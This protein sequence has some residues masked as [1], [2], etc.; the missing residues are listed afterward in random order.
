MSGQ[1]FE[2]GRT[3]YAEARRLGPPERLDTDWRSSMGWVATTLG[4]HRDALEEMEVLAARPETG[5]RDLLGLA[6]DLDEVGRTAEARDRL[7]AL[8]GRK[9]LDT[10]TRVE[11]LGMRGWLELKSPRAPKAEAPLREALEQAR[12]GL[13][14]GDPSR[15]YVRRL[16]VDVL[17]VLGEGARAEGACASLEGADGDTMTLALVAENRG[18]LDDAER[19]ARAGNPPQADP[20]YE[21][22]GWVTL[23]RIHRLQG[24]TDEARADL[25]RARELVAGC[26]QPVPV[27]RAWLTL[28][29][30]SLEDD[31]ALAE[32]ALRLLDQAGY[33]G[34]PWMAQ[35]HRIHADTLARRSRRAEAREA[36]GRPS[37]CWTSPWAGCTRRRAAP[38][39]ASPGWLPEAQT[40][41]SCK[42]PSRP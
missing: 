12:A 7:E 6:W 11:A 31:P 24:R 36:Y 13:T 38:S 29:T 25:G 39:S 10:A 35:A 15:A 5:P 17:L 34:G 41:A 28:E 14:P 33:T 4:Y 16:F 19:L 21:A 3:L 1:R 2:Q 30:A 42:R 37:A 23:A 22:S 18:R 40:A 32:E 20:A 9:D 8:L 27:D 26:P